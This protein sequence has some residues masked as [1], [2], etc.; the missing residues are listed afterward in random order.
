M[1][2]DFVRRRRDGRAARRG[3]SLVI[4]TALALASTA[5]ATA[6]DTPAASQD[7][8]LRIAVLDVDFV[9]VQ[10]PA[11]QQL[12]AEIAAMRQQYGQ[13]LATRQAEV[14]D[15][16]SQVAQVAEDDIEQQRLLQRRYQD[17]LTAF[18]RYQ[19]DVQAQAQQRQNEGLAKVRE[20]IGP[21]IEAVMREEGYDLILNT[22][23]PAVV[24]SS[25]R[26]DITQT[27]LE[28][29]QAGGG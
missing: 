4:A 9:A 12:A 25:E 10:S 17:A 29:L 24:M 6:Q 19:Q 3:R 27:V 7:A 18:Q 13:E 23:N 21:V 2:T 1:I 15:I 14:N 26:V 5:A 16:Q 8:P 11:G 22:A 20:E 28:R